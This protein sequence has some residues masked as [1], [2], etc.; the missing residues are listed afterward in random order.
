MTVQSVVSIDVDDKAFQRF[1]ALFEK[2]QTALAKN[3]S[4]WANVGKEQAAL[5]K[6]FEKMAAM[7][8]A[9]ARQAKDILQAEK[10]QATQLRNSDRLWTSIS[11]STRSVAS[12]IIGA[13]TSLIRWAGILGG[14]TGLLGFGGLWGIDRM[15][16]DVSDQRRS[17]MGL[18]MSIGQ[19]KAFGI[20]FGR[21]V[22]P[23]SYLSWINSMELD[24]TKQ[25]PAFALTGGGL[26]GNTETDAVRMLKAIRSLAQRTPLNTLQTTLEAYGLNLSDDQARRFKSMGNSEFMSLLTGNTRDISA[27]N[28]DAKTALAWTNFTRQMQRAGASIEKTFVTGLAPLAGPLSNLSKE[29]VS[30]L[31]T[32]LRKDGVVEQGIK[33]IATWID[34]FDVKVAKSTFLSDVKTITSATGDIA[35]WVRKFEQHPAETAGKT[36]A[37]A[38]W[39]VAVKY[40]FKAGMAYGDWLVAGASLP[41]GLRYNNP[42]NLKYAGQDNASRVFGGG[43]FAAFGTPQ[44]GLLALANQLEL[45]RSRGLNTISSIISRYAPPGE[46]DTAGYIKDIASRLGVGANAP[47]NLSNKA[48]L[49][50]LMNAIISHENANQNPYG[51]MVGQ[52]AGIATSRFGTIVRVENATGGSAHVTVAGLAQRDIMI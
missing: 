3:P 36:V 20:N 52:A 18:G 6:N 8:Q 27:T 16:G 14:V 43:G 44:A 23:G 13:T 26:T 25:G 11:H 22:D 9:Q 5:G 35:K 34:N 10:D 42:G 31:Q 32:A 37:K 12:N 29:L 45:D 33:A 19:Q 48:V 39:D 24:V 17:A 51:G 40:P 28:I 50:S 4:A 41:R 21:L 2:Y 15:A 7:A 47:L 30:V 38:A 46:N 49:T 1:A